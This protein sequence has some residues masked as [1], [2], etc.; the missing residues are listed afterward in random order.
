MTMAQAILLSA[1]QLPE[2]VLIYSH[3]QSKVS[4]YVT[5]V[6][7]RCLGVSLFLCV[8]LIYSVPCIDL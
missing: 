2:A 6:M 8:V 4:D 3:L 1:P 5:C 7:T